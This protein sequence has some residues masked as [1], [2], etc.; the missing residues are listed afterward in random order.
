M[1]V[2]SLNTVAARLHTCRRFNK[3]KVGWQGSVS[4]NKDPEDDVNTKFRW[5]QPVTTID[6]NAQQVGYGEIEALRKQEP[7]A[8]ITSLVMRMINKKE[9]QHLIAD[10][11]TPY[12]QL[13]PVL[14]SALL[15][16][17]LDDFLQKR[18][19]TC[20]EFNEDYLIVRNPKTT[21]Y[22]LR[23]AFRKKYVFLFFIF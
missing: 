20:D 11:L 17:E 15:R 7:S 14:I 8:D 9:V 6:K 21:S 5:D 18:N 3:S 1:N 12:D 19:V 22:E 16:D 23:Q 10:S 13:D 2:R 4:T